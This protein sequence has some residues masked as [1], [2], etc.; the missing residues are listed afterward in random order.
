MANLNLG[1]DVGRN[2]Q[3][4]I[5]IFSPLAS[6]SKS[7]LRVSYQQQPLWGHYQERKSVV[8]KQRISYQWNGFMIYQ[9]EQQMN[10]NFLFFLNR[11]FNGSIPIFFCR[12]IRKSKF[13]K[14]KKRHENCQGNSLK[15][16]PGQSDHIL[17]QYDA[18]EVR[19]LYQLTRDTQR[20]SIQHALN[21]GKP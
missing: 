20:E 5:H 18:V 3:L 14:R 4:L 19:G 2:R 11:K 16:E 1:Q 17:S 10:E 15:N 8:Q 13:G 9:Q 21:N 6:C 7:S 12:K